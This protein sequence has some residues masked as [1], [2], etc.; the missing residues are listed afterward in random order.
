NKN[1]IIYYNEYIT[2]KVPLEAFK[3]ELRDRSVYHNLLKSDSIENMNDVIKNTEPD[4][5]IK[6]I[7]KITTIAIEMNKIRER[8][9]EMNIFS[10][11]S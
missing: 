9:R 5:F 10:D 11:I 2:I 3:Y 1:G 7:K 8:L 6:M 4:Y